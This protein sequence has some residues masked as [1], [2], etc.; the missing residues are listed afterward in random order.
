MTETPIQQPEQG[1][2][3]VDAFLAAGGSYRHAAGPYYGA[4]GGRW[5]PESLIAAL[6]ELEETFEKAKKDPAFVA[7]IA[8]LNRNY[9]G[10][11]SLLTEAK[12]FSEHAGGVRVFLKREDLNHTGSHK[13][14]NVLGQAVLAKRMG[15]TRIIAETGAGQHGVA[16]ATAAALMGMECVVYMGEE[17][18][19]RQALNVA[20]MK[21][22]G[23]EVVPVTA[24]SRTLKDAINEALRDWVANVQNTHYLL[25][26]A[27]GAHPF[28][29]MVRYFH[30]V[31]GEEARAQI[32]EQTGRLPDAVCAC[33]GGG[34]NAI[35]IFHG[36]LDDPSVQLYGFE[37]GGDGVDTPRHAAT[38]TLGRPGVL[39]G[40]KTYLMQ[41]EDGQTIESHSISAGLDYPGVGPEHS[42]LHDSGRAVYE[43]VT[44]AEAM[45]AFSLLCRTEGIIPAIESS[46]ALAGALRLG[47]RMVDAGAV[48]QETVIIANLSG[49]GDKDVATAAEWFN[50]IKDAEGQGQ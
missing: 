10:R 31:I 49:R 26:T 11:P 16:S 5:M 2:E 4:Y 25:G 41:D 9:S 7:E 27:A 35:G 12:R 34:S 14:N 47:R 37:A 30:E 33:V 48:P 43:P 20:R 45:E 21:L 28:P 32:L 39:H 36:F 40:A 22:L 6:D 24:G 17:D 15:K 1:K 18:C 13:I 44:D 38:I 29:A 50:L 3:S 19:R 8:E 46:H 23:A 42:F